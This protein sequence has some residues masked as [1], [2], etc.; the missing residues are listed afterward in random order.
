MS[1]KNQHGI[2]WDDI[3]E[4]DWIDISYWPLIKHLF[5]VERKE[6]RNKVPSIYIRLADGGRARCGLEQIRSVVD[7]TTGREQRYDNNAERT[8]HNARS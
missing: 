7:R 8:M 1:L 6:I 5:E 2:K 3:N 4:G